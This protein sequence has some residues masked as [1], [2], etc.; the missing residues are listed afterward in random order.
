MATVKE[1]VT[2]LYNLYARVASLEYEN[3]LLKANNLKALQSTEYVWDKTFEI[4]Y[5]PTSEEDG[6][7]AIQ[8]LLQEVLDHVA[9]KVQVK[10]IQWKRRWDVQSSPKMCMWLTVG[11]KDD[12]TIV[13]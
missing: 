8:E 4:N 9:P 5:F 11:G 1:M 7:A 10:S 2:E 13:L 12:E 3:E 6:M